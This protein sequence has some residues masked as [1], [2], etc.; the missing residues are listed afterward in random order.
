M[1]F[2]LINGKIGYFDMEINGRTICSASARQ[3]DGPNSDNPT[4]CTAVSYAA[5]GKKLIRRPLSS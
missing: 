2:L 4:S 1:Y 5:E 3:T